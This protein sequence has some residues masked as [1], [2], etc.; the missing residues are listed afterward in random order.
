MSLFDEP[1]A[2]QQERLARLRGVLA[3]FE[4]VNLKN[5]HGYTF[6]LDRLERR[7]TLEETLS[8]SFPWMTSVIVSNMPN[9]RETIVPILEKWLFAFRVDTPTYRLIESS[10][11]GVFDSSRASWRRETAAG[12]ADELAAAIG[13]TSVWAVRVEAD[14]FY[15]LAWDDIAFETEDTVYLLHL[16]VSD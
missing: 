13:A 12:L 14:G 11:H 2:T 8:A 7:A 4:W 9:W 6:S 3:A 1:A 16:G 15:E 10:G 5:D